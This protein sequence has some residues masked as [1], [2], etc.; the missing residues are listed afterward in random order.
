M[1]GY[2]AEDVKEAITEAARKITWRE[3][4]VYDWDAYY[5]AEQ[6][7]LTKHRP[8]RSWELR[9]HPDRPDYTRD[10]KYPEPIV[11]EHVRE[12]AEDDDDARG[13]Y[14]SFLG[15]L[16]AS[17]KYGVEIDGIGTAF[18]EAEHG[19]EGQGDQY[20]FVFKLVEQRDNVV[21]AGEPQARYFKADGYYASYD[22]GY[23]DELYEVFPKQVQVTEWTQG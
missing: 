12:A 10:F 2:T 3:V 20:W 6:A 21:G 17:G 22:G 11:T 7:F 9:D 1:T 4:D 23:Y 18:L 13:S 19:G 8:A 16:N 14:D 15:Y 5:A